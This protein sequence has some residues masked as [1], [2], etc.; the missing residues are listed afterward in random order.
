MAQYKIGLDYYAH[1][2]GMTADRRLIEIRREYG[3]AGIDVWFSLLDII[4]SQTGY[5][6]VYNDS[7]AGNLLWDIAGLVRGKNAP[8][9]NT[10]AQIIDSLVKAELFDTELFEKGIL[11][12]KQIQEQFYMSTLR[13][14]NVEVIKEYWLLSAEKMKTLSEKSPILDFLF[15]D[16]SNVDIKAQNVDI[17]KQSKVKHS[18]TK[19]KESKEKKIESKAE[20]TK[21]P[22]RE[23]VSYADFACS[24]EKNAFFTDNADNPPPSVCAD[25]EKTN[26]DT[27]G[28]SRAELIAEYGECEIKRY[29]EK[30]L[31]WVQSSGA[32]NAKMYPQIK[33]WLCEDKIMRSP[34]KSFQT[35]T[36][37]VD[38]TVADV[39][40]QY[41]SDA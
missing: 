37:D 7:T 10:I 27:D 28:I 21:A 39:M 30:F 1:N 15:S 36:I 23:Q 24:A 12:S 16:N 11:T 26:G 9:E 31:R 22:L 6:L 35:S 32:K 4:Y 34:K 25:T 3:S 29:E 8:D 18:K 19:Q 33:K 20:Q 17:L 2:V 38:S 14:K 40:R 41:Q 13:R 5:Y